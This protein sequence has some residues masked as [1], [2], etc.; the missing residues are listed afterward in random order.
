MSRYLA[1]AV[2]AAL[3]FFAAPVPGRGAAAGLRE[4]RPVRSPRQRPALP[5]RRI[6]IFEL[7][8]KRGNIR[9]PAGSRSGGEEVRVPGPRVGLLRERRRGS[10][11][12]LGV[13]ADLAWRGIVLTPQLAVGISARATASTWGARWSSGIAR[14]LVSVGGALARG[15]ILRPYLEREY[16][17]REPGQEDLLLTIAAGF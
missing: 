7:T 14:G 15:G 5:R 3:V 12:Y 2:A 1:F 6:R 17:Q 8:D 13:Y 11:R 9:R 4:G 16:P 10:F